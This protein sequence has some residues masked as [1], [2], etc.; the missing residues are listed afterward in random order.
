[1]KLLLLSVVFIFL[2]IHTNAQTK[3][4]VVLP[5][6]NYEAQAKFTEPKWEQGNIIILDQNKYKTTVNSIRVK[7]WLNDLFSQFLVIILESIL[8]F[9]Y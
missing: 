3:Q 6:G 2:M 9:F 1:M 4:L 5:A 7:Q 8:L